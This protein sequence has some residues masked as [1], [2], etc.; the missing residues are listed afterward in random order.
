MQVWK[1][2]P[3]CSS[4]TQPSAPGATECSVRRSNS[5]LIMRRH[6]YPFCVY[7]DEVS[8]IM[9]RVANRYAPRYTFFEASLVCSTL[10]LNDTDVGVCRHVHM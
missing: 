2:Y 3:R 10:A 8:Q 6:V 7:D 5:S 4:S 9:D 1:T